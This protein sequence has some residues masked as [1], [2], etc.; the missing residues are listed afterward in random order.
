MPEHGEV[1]CPGHPP[2]TKY[3]PGTECHIRCSRSHKLNGPHA[4]SC[5]KDGKWSGDISI[6]VRE[7]YSCLL[8]QMGPGQALKAIPMLETD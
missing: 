4:R 3:P 6:C 7:Y 2:E 1:R 5:G 8:L